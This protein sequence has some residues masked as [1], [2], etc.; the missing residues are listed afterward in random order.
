MRVAFRVDASQAIGT[1]HVRRCLAL[2]HA[3]RAV[4]VECRFV[5][6]DLGVDSVGMIGREA[7]SAA[8]LP[9]PDGPAEPDARVVHSA[10]AGVTLAVDVAQTRTA[11]AEWAPDW[12]VID[13]YAFDSRW[14]EE[15]RAALGCRIAAI[16]DFAD[17][18]LACDLLIDHN[19]A[20]DH[21]TKYGEHLPAEVVLL[22]G[23][24]YALLGPVFANAPRY[25]PRATVQ[26]I[27]VF[28]GGVDR[29]N[30]SARVLDAIG[31]AG[32]EGPVE[33]V[34]TSANP[35]LAALRAAAE[36]RASTVLSVD[37]GDL[38]AFFARH[39]L[40]VGAGGGASWERCCI[41]VP[42][43]LLVVAENQLAV[44]PDLAAGGIVATPE[45]PDSL[46]ARAIAR[47]IAEL[48]D[49]SA[50][51]AGLAAKARALVDGRGAMRVA[52]VMKQWR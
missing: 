49:D 48:I 43:L 22:G 20:R 4:G 31:L 19:H 27:G 21:R 36:A 14:H 50:R 23:P 16:D 9:A 1:G 12:V 46:D 38:A 2:A 35:H 11:L 24:E 52:Q 32:F 7:F 28:M 34:A 3:L 39:D 6:R 51:R 37:L 15:I 17:R 33:I 18:R 45:P 42:T 29:A 13:H 40:Q 30:L 8:L 10:W 5:T 47:A 26:S 44:V 25:Q 41:G